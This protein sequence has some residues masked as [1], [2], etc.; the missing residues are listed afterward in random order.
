MYLPND[1]FT[2][3]D[4]S[5]N[6]YK[7]ILGE[8]SGIIQRGIQEP[9]LEGGN[10]GAGATGVSVS[11]QADTQGLPGWHDGDVKVGAETFGI[12]LSGVDKAPSCALNDLVEHWRLLPSIE[13]SVVVHGLH[14]VLAS[15]EHRQRIAIFSGRGVGKV[16]HCGEYG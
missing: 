5:G 9:D 10:E 1:I 7:G 2:S 16:T 4:S 12:I 14:E 15:F 11:G 6:G 3:K 8:V 13:G